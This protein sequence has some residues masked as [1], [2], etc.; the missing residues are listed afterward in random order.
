M[1][2]R[3]PV[4]P[5]S[6][7]KVN[8]A[9]LVTFIVPLRDS[10]SQ[11][12]VPTS[13][14][15]STST[16]APSKVKTRVGSPKPKHIQPSPLLVSCLLIEIL[17]LP[18]KVS[19]LLNPLVSSQSVSN[20]M[21][22]PSSAFSTASSSVAYSVSPIFA[23]FPPTGAPSTLTGSIVTTMAAARTQDINRFTI[24]FFIVTSSLPFITRLF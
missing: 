16:P 3:L 9:P 13:E 10:I 19:V 18:V 8:L 24:V 5:L 4:A 6:T 2:L 15:H 11:G 23:T 12:E 22:A 17:P 20:S 21:V 1:A 7:V 14:F